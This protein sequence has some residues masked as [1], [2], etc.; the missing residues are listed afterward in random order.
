[1]IVPF[2]LFPLNLPIHRGFA[3]ISIL[4][5]S[6]DWICPQQLA[7]LPPFADDHQPKPSSPFADIR[8]FK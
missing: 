1:M 6:N 7:I 8:W 3:P 4:F 2:S 5:W